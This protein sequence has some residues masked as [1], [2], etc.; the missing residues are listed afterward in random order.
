MAP[1]LEPLQGAN[2]WQVLA[3]GITGLVRLLVIPAIS[4]KTYMYNSNIGIL[5]SHHHAPKLRDMATH[6]SEWVKC[7]H[8][9]MC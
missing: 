5:A 8:N 6:P 2:Y 4:S 9:F 3:V 7:H 1:V